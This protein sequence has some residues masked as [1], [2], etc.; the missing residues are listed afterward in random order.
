MKK[1]NIAL[2]T[3]LCLMSAFTAKAELLDRPQG[4]QFGSRMTLM[5]SV[6]LSVGYDSNPGSTHGSNGGDGDGGD[7]MWVISPAFNLTYKA[8]QWSLLLNGYYN[9]TAYSKNTNAN[10]HNNHTFGEDLRWNWANSVGS[11]KGW[12]VVLGQG[13]RQQTMADE[14]L[15]T[16]G[17]GYQND[18]RQ[19]QFSGSAQRRFNEQFHGDINA[20]YYWLDYMDC[21]NGPINQAFYGWDRWNVGLELGW[22]PSQWT[23]IIIS[24]QYQSYTQENNEGYADIDDTSK[25]LTFQAGLGSYMTERISYRALVGWSRFDYGDGASTDDGFVYTL[26]GNWKIGETWNTMLLATSYY[27]PSERQQASKSRVDSISWGLSKTLINGKM[28]AGLDIIYHRDTN[29]YVQDSGYDYN[30]DVFTGSLSLNYQFNRIIGA[31]VRGEYQRSWNSESDS[32]SGA[33]DYDRWRAMIG[34]RLSY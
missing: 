5:P 30:V 31:Y 20:S 29:E 23:D 13:Y 14:F 34:I 28:S 27:Q 8:E 32:R 1:S 17:R 21:E 6:A 2:L 3:A 18:T 11:E 10:N 7:V 12:A 25:G 19:L 26:S 4:V 15:Q 24:G 22:A 33:Y 16:N 9:Y